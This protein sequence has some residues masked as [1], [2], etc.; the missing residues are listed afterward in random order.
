MTT[1]TALALV[2]QE[3][4]IGECVQHMCHRSFGCPDP[5]FHL[6]TATCPTCECLFEGW[7]EHAESCPAI[8]IARLSAICKVAAEKRRPADVKERVDRYTALRDQF[9]NVEDPPDFG[10]ASPFYDSD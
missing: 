6:A 9:K 2:V 3:V 5:W 4:G 10:S 8:A 7:Q 1:T